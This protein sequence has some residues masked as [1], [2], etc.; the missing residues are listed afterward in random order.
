MSFH[1]KVSRVTGVTVKFLFSWLSSQSIS[2]SD[3]VDVC[4][5]VQDCHKLTGILF[6]LCAEID[7]TTSDHRLNSTFDC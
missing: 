1:G 6:S 7:I 3:D 5:V 2:H 4:F